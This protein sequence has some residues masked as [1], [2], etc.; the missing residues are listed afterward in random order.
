MITP[1]AADDLDRRMRAEA[2]PCPKCQAEKPTIYHG[3]RSDGVALADA[4]CQNCGHVWVVRPL[5]GA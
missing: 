3:L 2:G 4:E 1:T 5:K